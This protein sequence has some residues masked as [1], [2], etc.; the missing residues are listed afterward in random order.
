MHKRIICRSDVGF[1]RISLLGAE[2]LG[3]VECLLH[4]L[5]QLAVLPE[6]LIA[7]TRRFNAILRKRDRRRNDVRIRKRRETQ[8]KKGG[9]RSDE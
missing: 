6:V 8:T 4:Q 2:V 7:A 3:F 9:S 1:H 5:A